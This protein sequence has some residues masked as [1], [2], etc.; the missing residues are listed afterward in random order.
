M[1]IMNSERAF[2]CVSNVAKLTIAKTNA[3]AIVGALEAE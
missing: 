1:L 3:G 2:P